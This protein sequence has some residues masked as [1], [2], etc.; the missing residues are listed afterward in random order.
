MASKMYYVYVLYSP[1]HD[2]TYIGMT[3]DYG[4]RLREH[5]SG[6]TKSTKAFIPWIVV[7]LEAYVTREEARNREKYLKSAAG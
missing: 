1:S 6:R 7:H 4:V 5:N 2:R 3:V